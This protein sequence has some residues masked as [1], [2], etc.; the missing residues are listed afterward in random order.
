MRSELEEHSAA[1]IAVAQLESELRVNT[2]EKVALQA[3]AD[4]SQQLVERMEARV[5]LAEAEAMRLSGI[6]SDLNRSPAE[7]QARLRAE[8]QEREREW[9]EMLRRSDER[10][11][12]TQLALAR[13][14]RER[15]EMM[16]RERRR[17]SLEARDRAERSR[18]AAVLNARSALSSAR[19]L[20]APLA[21]AAALN[22]ACLFAA[23]AAAQ[24]SGTID[25]HLDRAR[26]LEAAQREWLDAAAQQPEDGLPVPFSWGQ[27]SPPRQSTRGSRAVGRA[28]SKAIV[29]FRLRRCGFTAG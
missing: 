11:A 10:A 28:R 21:S 12:P 15:E 20:L 6:R 4:G 5:K 16:E 29:S 3:K 2:A 18:K 1:S 14:A 17:Q 9:Q 26:E 24:V 27:G 13:A 22:L 19:R 23:E 8:I 7:N 25:E